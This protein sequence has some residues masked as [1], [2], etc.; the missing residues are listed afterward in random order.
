MPLLQ[1][2]TLSRVLLIGNLL[3]DDL[4]ITRQNRLAKYEEQ[5]LSP[6]NKKV[7]VELGRVVYDL[8]SLEEGQ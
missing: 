2:Q 1:D 4:V 5:Q 3:E 6:G 8:H 7:R